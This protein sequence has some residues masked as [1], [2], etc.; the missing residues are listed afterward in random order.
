[1]RAESGDEFGLLLWCWRAAERSQKGAFHQITGGGFSLRQVQRAPAKEFGQH[2]PICEINGFE[3]REI[4]R[5]HTDDLFAVWPS[6]GTLK[7]ICRDERGADHFWGG[8]AES[9]AEW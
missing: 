1:M 6:E 3:G 8:G 4:L 9:P 5:P 2:F 7:W